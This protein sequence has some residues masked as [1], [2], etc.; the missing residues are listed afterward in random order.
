MKK[1]ALIALFVLII[2]TGAFSAATNQLSVYFLD[3][4]QGDCEILQTGNHTIVIDTATEEMAPRIVSFLKSK[5]TQTI[6]LLIQTHPHADHIGSASEV[7][8]AFSVSN[9]YMPKVTTNTRIFEKL[10]NTL[11]SQGKT[12]HAPVPG[13]ALNI[14]DLR[15]DFLAPYKPDT[16]NLNNDSIVCK[17]TFG[18]IKVLFM[19]DAEKPEEKDIFDHGSDLGA[20][21]LKVAHHGSNSST[22]DAFLKKADPQYAVIEVAL[23]NDYGHPSPKTVN[24]LEKTHG[25]K[26]F[27]TS[28]NGTIEMRTDGQSIQFFVEKK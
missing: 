16:E 19:G 24:R 11:K 10:I 12:A 8:S 28:L 4:G 23:H 3:V 18:V 17:L 7:L 6:D 2:L 25:I 20:N 21:V 26:V 1:F 13:E 15:F 9:V 14:G 5:N 22:T 27:Q